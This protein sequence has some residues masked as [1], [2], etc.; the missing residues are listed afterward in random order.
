MDFEV[1]SDYRLTISFTVFLV[2]VYKI[3]IIYKLTNAA[4]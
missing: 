4:S 1:V 3:S 2:Q